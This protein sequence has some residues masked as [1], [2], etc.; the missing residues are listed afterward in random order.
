MR[1]L[2]LAHGMKDRWVA[3]GYP[4]FPVWIP[5]VIDSGA[6]A[7]AIVAVAQRA[8]SGDLLPAAALVALALV[9]WLTELRG[10]VAPWPVFVLVTGGASAVLMVRYPVDYDFVPFLLV[11]MVG[12]V[13]ACL[14]MTRSGAT[15]AATAGVLGGLTWADALPGAAA[16]IWLAGL[17]I[18]WDVGFILRALQLRIQTQESEYAARERQIALE[19]RQ[20]IAREVHDLVA[21]SLSVTMLHLTA[22]RRDLEDGSDVAEAIDALKDAERV[23]RQ[24]MADVR[25]TVGLLS[26]GA[27]GAE[28][29]TPQV[30]DV[31][32]LVDSFRAAG[33][34]V[35]YWCRGDV[36][37]VPAA[38]GL[39]LYRI[40]QESL[41]NVAKHAPGSRV[42]VRVALS[43]DPGT[44]TIRNA[45]ARE[46]LSSGSPGG[47]GLTGM[48]ARADLLGATFAAGPDG[49]EWLVEV[50]LP[51]GDTAPVATGGLRCPLPR[52]AQLRRTVV[53]PA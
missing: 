13:G 4:D 26:Q 53:D 45:L 38:T 31:P 41:A 51:R 10:R 12:H 47:S 42:R 16:A 32:A 20:R 39:G 22:A 48:A 21:H 46:A 9:P 40:V 43:R 2:S 49:R 3:N 23:G 1:A 19:E 18:G 7:A 36:D 25:S 14:P 24:A 34:D 37:E 27:G 29:P 44:L 6:F 5:L 33:L 50:G 35:D 52:L 11:L 15:L 8:G 28:P 17:M 30:G